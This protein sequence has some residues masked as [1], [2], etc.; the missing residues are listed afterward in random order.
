[1]VSLAHSI[2]YLMLY[3]NF[4]VEV[5]CFFYKTSIDL[6]YLISLDAYDPRI[7]IFLSLCVGC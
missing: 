1:M 4:F 7:F 5:I 6:L 2:I 3:C